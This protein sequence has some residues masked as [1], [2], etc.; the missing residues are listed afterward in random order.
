[1]QKFLLIRFPRW[2]HAVQALLALVLTALAAPAAHA[3]LPVVT[4]LFRQDTA[5]PQQRTVTGRITDETNQALPGVTVSI[6]GTGTGAVTDNEGKFSLNIRSAKATLI[7]SSMGFEKQ[8]IAFNGQRTIN[9]QLRPDQKALGEVVVVGYG[10]QKKVNLVGAVS[11]VKVDQK[12]ASRAVPNA[13]SAL[14][15]LVPGL[16]V[17]QASG[18]AGKKS[19]GLVIRGL[20]TVNNASPLVVV[21]GM[22]D[23]DINRINM[24]DVESISVLK[25]AT[26]AAVYGSSAANGVILITTKS[27]KGQRKTQINFN[28]N[29]ALVKPTKA[30]KF[31]AD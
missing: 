15:G 16:A 1:M 12:L 8:E 29:F 19:A 5:Q 23:V 10:T 4:A 3:A 26:S 13:S 28:S 22:P 20:G 31:L 25:D 7:L 2:L 18:M 30:Y 14:S 6:K 17:T 11:A 21:D 9:A 24:N 27:G